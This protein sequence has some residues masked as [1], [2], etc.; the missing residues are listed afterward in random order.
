MSIQFIINN[1]ALYHSC[2]KIKC[3]KVWV[4]INYRKESC[5]FKQSWSNSFSI[6]RGFFLF[7]ENKL[8]TLVM[9]LIVDGPVY[10]I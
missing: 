2:S 1:V 10:R 3:L 8:F 5:G 9:N 7:E 4:L 6:I